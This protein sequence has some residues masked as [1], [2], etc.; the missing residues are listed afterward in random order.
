MRFFPA[1]PPALA[2]HPFH[3]ARRRPP[4]LPRFLALAGL[5]A[6]LGAL[7]GTPLGALLAGPAHAGDAYMVSG[8]HLFP[9]YRVGI[10]NL[11]ISDGRVSGTLAAPAGDPRPPLPLSGSLADGALHLVIGSGAEGY[12][13]TLFDGETEQFQ[14]WDEAQRLP[15]ME[16]VTF[17]RPKEGFSE[18]ALVLQHASADWC[19]RVSGGLAVTLRPEALKAD[20]EAPAAFADLEVRLVPQEASE[21]RAKVRDVWGRLRLAAL[22]GRPVSFDAVVPPGSEVATAKALRALP[23][24]AA[25]NLPE[26][27]G[28][29]AIVAVPRGEIME[30]G[31]VSDSKLKSFAEAQLGRLLS[32][33]AP[34]G[35]ATGRQPYRILD[36]AVARDAG[37]APVFRA[38]IVARASADR[39]QGEGWD[40]FTLALRP[41]VT[42]ADTARTVTLIP[43]VGEVRTAPAG[44]QPPADGAFAAQD[45][46]TV[47]AAIAH[48]FVSWLAAGLETRCS[49]H[50][51]TDFQQPE[52]AQTCGNTSIDTVQERDYE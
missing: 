12:A 32:G 25:V 39:A 9:P 14:T 13:I 22:D 33:A 27:C 20:A 38:T 23:L 51:E 34:Q 52:E 6:L 46:D 7:L 40:R 3:L 15:E 42:P 37:G 4:A 35:R 5:C 28:E 30:G 43:A 49:F 8:A 16:V 1:L 26:S 50:T 19:G 29:L 45:D 18:P 47:P 24:V 44:A 31:E 17:F 48:R 41:L 36:A 11:D 2:P 21:G 10:A